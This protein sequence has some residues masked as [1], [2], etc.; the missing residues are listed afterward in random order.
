M[1]ALANVGLCSVW[2]RVGGALDLLVLRNVA[3]SR[4]VLVSCSVLCILVFA[5]RFLVVISGSVAI[6]CIRCSNLFSGALLVGV[7]SLNIDW[8]LLVVGFR[9]MRVLV[10]V[11]VVR[12]VLVG[13]AIA[14]IMVA[15]VLRNW[16]IILVLG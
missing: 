10:F 2:W 8:R 3:L 5:A 9:M 16:C 11:L 4:M 6:V 12:R 7:R 15:L 13:C 14:M 1:M